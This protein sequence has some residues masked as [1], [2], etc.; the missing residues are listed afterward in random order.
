MK[1]YRSVISSRFFVTGS[2]WAPWGVVAVL[3]VGM[4]AC[5]GS[6]ESRVSSSTGSAVTSGCSGLAAA[7]LSWEAAQLA[8]GESHSDECLG[9]VQSAFRNA[10]N[11]PAYLEGGTAAESLAKAQAT[12]DFVP[13]D[14]S[15]PC[16]GILYWAA[17]SVNPEDGHV[18]ICN[19]D[20]TASTAG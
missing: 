10:G 20:G 11:E 14:G 8:A 9:F 2:P 15:C 18:V 3:S 6:S 12:G 7:A 19:G 5:G 17:N 1:T 4:T 13:W 16:G